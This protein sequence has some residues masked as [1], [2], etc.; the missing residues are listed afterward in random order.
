MA[1]RDEEEMVEGDSAEAKMCLMAQK[2]KA[3]FDKYWGKI[4][5][6]NMMVLL[7]AVLDPQCKMRLIRFCY[8]KL[9]DDFDKVNSLCNKI[10]GVLE[11]TYN[12]YKLASD[13]GTVAASSS[14]KSQLHSKIDESSV[15]VGVARLLKLEFQMGMEEEE[16][17]DGKSEVDRYLEE[18]CEKVVENFDILNWWK[19]NSSKYKV[20]SEIARDVLAIPVSTV[21]SESAFSTGGRVIDQFRSSLTPKLVESLICMQ[22][23]LRAPHALSY[24]VEENI[25]D[26]EDLEIGKS[27]NFNWY[28][29]LYS[30]TSLIFF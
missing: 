14:R 18:P 22:D 24:E 3:K 29:I 19:V 5:K 13:S 28:S 12:E 6:V 1:S 10:K 20:L 26:L 23:W 8:G 7:A 30:L 15:G 9:Y 21:A 17:M 25:E 11:C 2:M 16:G 27:I 4:E